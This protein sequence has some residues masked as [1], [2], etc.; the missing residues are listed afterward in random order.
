[1]SY[2]YRVPE[3]IRA[4]QWS[5]TDTGKQSQFLSLLLRVGVRV[6]EVSNE[7]VCFDGKDAHPGEWVVIPA[8]GS[9]VQVMNDWHFTSLY[10]VN[11]QMEADRRHDAFE[12]DSPEE[13]ES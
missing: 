11:P 1:M 2:F 10:H 13:E 9:G 7:Q 12:E 6:E 8:D 3:R 5:A 4:A